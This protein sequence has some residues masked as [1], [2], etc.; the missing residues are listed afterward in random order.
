MVQLIAFG[1]LCCLQGTLFEHADFV[2]TL[3]SCCVCH[4]YTL[5]IPFCMGGV[6]SPVSLLLFRVTTVWTMDEKPISNMTSQ[7]IRAGQRM[8]IQKIAHLMAFSM[9][10][11]SYSGFASEQPRH[12][13]LP[14]C[15][16]HGPIQQ[17]CLSYT[18]CDIS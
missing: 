12:L 1:V 16:H 10:L 15:R 8:S 17:A 7:P 5:Y 3:L 6:H 13:Q 14:Q 4:F 2:K 9:S 11:A 18:Y